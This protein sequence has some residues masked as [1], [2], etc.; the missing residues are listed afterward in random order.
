MYT[1]HA[2][3]CFVAVKYQTD[4]AISSRNTSISEGHYDWKSALPLV[5]RSQDKTKFDFF[6]AADRYI[7]LTAKHNED[8]FVVDYRSHDWG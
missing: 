8:D 3:L 5:S 4:I 2:L 1:I 7:L 6:D